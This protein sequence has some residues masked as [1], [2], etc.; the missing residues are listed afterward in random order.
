MRKAPAAALLAALATAPALHAQAC[1]GVP[2]APGALAALVTGG[3]SSYDIGGSV[4]GTSLGA[5]VRARLRGPLAAVAG[6]TYRRVGYDHT[7]MHVVSGT[8][9]YRLP[10]GS[11][12]LSVCARAGAFASRFSQPGS[13]TELD[14][15]SFPLGGAVEAT[16]PVGTGTTLAPYVAPSYVISR[17]TGTSFGYDFEGRKSGLGVEAGVGLRHGRWVANAAFLHTGLTTNVGPAALPRQMLTVG[18]GVQI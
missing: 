15:L 2:L 14:N 6:Y 13:D 10:L 1:I 8:L 9:S 5:D 16:L 17:T 3:T 12:R 11:E 4:S 7:P 18:F